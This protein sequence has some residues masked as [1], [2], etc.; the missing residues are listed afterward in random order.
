M[1]D[2]RA[3]YLPGSM[4]SFPSCLEQLK[5]PLLAPELVYPGQV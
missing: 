3:G 4:L 2:E 5:S 1:L